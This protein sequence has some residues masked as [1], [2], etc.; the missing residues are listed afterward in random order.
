[1]LALDWVARIEEGKGKV[2]REG[3]GEEGVYPNGPFSKSA[4]G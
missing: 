2:T 1:M 4:R 3:F